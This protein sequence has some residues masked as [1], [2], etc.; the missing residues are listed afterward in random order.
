MIYVPHV[1]AEKFTCPHSKFPV[2]RLAGT[3]EK[4]PDDMLY[5]LALLYRLK[6]KVYDLA[7]KIFLVCEYMLHRIDPGTG[8]YERHLHPGCPVTEHFFHSL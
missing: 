7:V 2:K 5:Y 8:H 3:V 1:P 4:S 6:R